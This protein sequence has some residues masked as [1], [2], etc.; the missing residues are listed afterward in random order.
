M[1]KKLFA[2]IAAA[3]A[4]VTGAVAIKMRKRR[5]ASYKAVYVRPPV[6]SR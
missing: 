6:M 3:A 5:M 2:A 1:T 4:A